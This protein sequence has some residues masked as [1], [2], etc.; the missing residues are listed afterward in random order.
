MRPYTARVSNKNCF[1]ICFATLYLHYRD[2]YDAVK[3]LLDDWQ[4]AHD[5]LNEGASLKHI[6]ST[7]PSRRPSVRLRHHLQAPDL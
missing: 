7:V 5:A 4:M 6:H 3:D 2:L 1:Y